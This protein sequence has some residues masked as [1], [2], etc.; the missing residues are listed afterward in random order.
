MSGIIYHCDWTR[1]LKLACFKEISKIYQ[2]K[3][4]YP[5]KFSKQTELYAAFAQ[6]KLSDLRIMIEEKGECCLKWHMWVYEVQIHR[7]EKI[8]V[9]CRIRNRP[10]S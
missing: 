1:R 7:M 3:D 2:C 5:K 10:N 8:V 6:K 4:G 9:S